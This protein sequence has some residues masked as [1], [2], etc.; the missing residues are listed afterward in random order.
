MPRLGRVRARLLFALKSLPTHLALQIERGSIRIRTL[1]P[2]LRR[3]RLQRPEHALALSAAR[4][5]DARAEFLGRVGLRSEHRGVVVDP[6]IDEQRAALARTRR[7]RAEA[8]DAAGLD[9]DAR[10]LGSVV[11]CEDREL[12]AAAPGIWGEDRADVLVARMP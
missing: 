7:G 8:V 5:Y 3:E 10:D 6:G 4:G 2:Q 12:D 1:S 11:R 9:V